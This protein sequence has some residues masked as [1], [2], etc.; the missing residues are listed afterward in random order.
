M[1]MGDCAN[2]AGCTLSTPIYLHSTFKTHLVGDNAD[3]EHSHHYIA[4]IH[5]RLLILVSSSDVFLKR[6]HGR[7][8]VQEEHS[9]TMLIYLQDY[10]HIFLVILCNE[11][12]PVAVTIAIYDM[13]KVHKAHKVLRLKAVRIFVMLKNADTTVVRKIPLFCSFL[14][15]HYAPQEFNWLQ[16]LERDRKRWKKSYTIEKQKSLRTLREA[17]F[18]HEGY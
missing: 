18:Y 10:T 12:P 16:K 8:E 5:C 4:N 1:S 15:L 6:Q 9:I 13:H 2:A 7:T 17:S 14:L 3:A 11:R